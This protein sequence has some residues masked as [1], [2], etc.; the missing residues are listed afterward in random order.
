MSATTSSYIFSTQERQRLASYRAA[1]RAGFYSEFPGRRRR[2]DVHL[3]QRLLRPRPGAPEYPFSEPELERLAACRAAVAR[4][5]YSD[6]VL[7]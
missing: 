6:T 4:G 5:F 1:V 2:T 7:K 3:M